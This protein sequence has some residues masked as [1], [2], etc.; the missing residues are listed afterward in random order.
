MQDIFVC[1]PIFSWWVDHSLHRKSSEEA[2]VYVLFR[3]YYF[4]MFLSSSSSVAA[5]KFEYKQLPN[6]GNVYIASRKWENSNVFRLQSETKRKAKN[7]GAHNYINVDLRIFFIFPIHALTCAHTH[8]PLSYVQRNANNVKNENIQRRQ[9]TTKIKR[10]AFNAFVSWRKKTQKI[11]S[12]CFSVVS[13][14]VWVRAKQLDVFLLLPWFSQTRWSFENGWAFLFDLRIE[15]RLPVEDSNLLIFLTLKNDNGRNEWTTEKLEH[16]KY[17]EPSIKRQITLSQRQCALLL[18]FRLLL[19]LVRFRTYIQ[20]CEE[21]KSCRL[22][23]Q[24]FWFMYCS[25][26]ARKLRLDNQISRLQHRPIVRT[27]TNV[28][29]HYHKM[30]FPFAFWWRIQSKCQRTQSAND[31]LKFSLRSTY[32]AHNTYSN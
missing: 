2:N 32:I 27:H 1:W 20:R 12:N 21:R 17:T 29:A 28:H 15:F 8:T 26:F 4:D 6:I 16:T 13:L 31:E 11:N 9:N 5:V 18:L 3:A 23:R 22:F 14:F 7:C 30:D 24:K 10:L 25:C 19:I